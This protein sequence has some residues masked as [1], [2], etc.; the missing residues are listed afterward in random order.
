MPDLLSR[1][2]N[3]NMIMNAHPLSIAIHHCT[4]DL[5]LTFCFPTAM[6]GNGRVPGNDLSISRSAYSPHP[7]GTNN[8]HT[9]KASL[10]FGGAMYLTLFRS[11]P[12]QVPLH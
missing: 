2:D 11:H 3:G 5:S 6:A 1:D 4:L 9:H 7:A 8:K 10:K 12:L